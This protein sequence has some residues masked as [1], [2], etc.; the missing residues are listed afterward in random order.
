MLA[1]DLNLDPAAL[2]VGFLLLGM[3]VAAYLLPWLIA[4]CRG[5]HNAT[6]I[7]VL[8]LFLGWTLLGWIGALVWSCTVV[9][10][11]RNV[12]G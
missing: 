7:F 1:R 6:A 10:L 8:N 9:Q 4:L 11:P 5:H 2:I 3:L 12:A